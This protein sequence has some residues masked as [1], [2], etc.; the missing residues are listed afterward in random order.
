MHVT[1]W[2]EESD[3]S[4]GI[5]VSLE[6]LVALH[7]V[8][9]SRVEAVHFNGLHGLDLGGRP[10]LFLIPVDG[11]HMIGISGSERD[12][13]RVESRQLRKLGLLLNFEICSLS[14]TVLTLKV[15]SLVERF[16]GSW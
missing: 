15:L 3:L 11:E 5:F 12:G 7:S 4:L 14:G 6:T 1:L 9:E 13:L 10:S 8:V 16:K 2:P